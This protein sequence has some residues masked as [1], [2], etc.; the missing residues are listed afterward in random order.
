MDTLVSRVL[1]FAE[2]QPD[3]PAL[4]EGGRRVTYGELFRPVRA[5][6]GWLHRAGVRAGDT[7]ALSLADPG[8]DAVRSAR[9]FYA[10]AHLGAVILPLYPDVPVARRLDLI[11][12][13]GA[14][15]LIPREAGEPAGG[16]I[17]I[18]PA[19]FDWTRDAPAAPRGDDP[20]RPFL[21]HLSG[22]TTG[23]PKAVLVDHARF[24]QNMIVGAREVGA[25]ASDRLVSSRRWPALPGLRYLLRIQSIGGAL[26]DAEFPDTRQ[27]LE[28][29]IRDTGAT[30]L[31]ASPWQLR[32]ILAS[33]PPTGARETELN[34]LYVVG[35]LVTPD[36][37]RAAREIITRNV[38][39]TYATSEAGLISV[40]R[41]DDPPG[42]VGDFGRLI[43]GIEGQVTDERGQPV[44]PGIA[45]DLS[46]RAPWFPHAYANN[47]KASAERFRGGWFYPGD[48]GTID[49]DGRITYRGRTDDVINFG[50]VKLMP[51]DIEAVIKEHPDVEDVAVVAVPHAMA[52]SVPVALVVMRRAVSSEAL[53]AFCETK[54]DATQVPAGFFGVPVIARTPDGKIQRNLMVEQYALKAGNA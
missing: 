52:G 54:L 23:V 11:S 28:D 9:I 40:L 16:C 49:A 48:M 46:F 36:E 45:G 35:G 43:A 25:K 8:G 4:L 15:W 37:I 32:R 42:G 14:K 2:S 22:G 7:V 5:A 21:Y 3:A 27:K 24:L 50:G 18:D 26:V 53:T 34:V 38:Y 17:A 31:M 29:V 20:G 30:I 13:F 10:L 39:A 1:T 33:A 44:A 47:E 51:A 12:R 41:P 19:T 6:A